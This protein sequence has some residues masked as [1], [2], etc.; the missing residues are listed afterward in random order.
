MKTLNYCSIL[1]KIIVNVVILLEYLRFKRILIAFYNIPLH[2]WLRLSFLEVK[3]EI[4]FTFSAPLQ[5]TA[6]KT[7]ILRRNV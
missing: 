6:M 3:A 2:C 7:G 5:I 4:L 1:P